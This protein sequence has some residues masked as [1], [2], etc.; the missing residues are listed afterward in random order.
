MTSQPAP[1]VEDLRAI[2]DQV[3]TSYLDPDGTNGLIPVPDGASSQD[4]TASVSVTGAW[5]G[6]VVVSCSD[7]AA[8]NAA[9]ALL[10]VDRQDVTAEDVTDAVGELVNIIGGNVKALLPEP[11]ALSLPHVLINGNSRWPAVIEVCQLTG[12][13]LAEPVSVRVLASQP[14]KEA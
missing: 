4:V 1:T 2:S 6:H 10:A 14:T 9:A 5:R 11:S 3:W 8:R 7:A 13:W 12:T